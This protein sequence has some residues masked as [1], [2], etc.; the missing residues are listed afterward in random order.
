MLRVKERSTVG[1][2]N[3]AGKAILGGTLTAGQ[4]AL[5]AGPRAGSSGAPTVE[6]EATSAEAQNEL[7]ALLEEQALRQSQPQE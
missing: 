6:N 5:R 1:R 7:K 4:Q 3:D 2:I